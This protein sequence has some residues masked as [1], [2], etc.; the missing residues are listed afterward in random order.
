MDEETLS[1]I[2]STP[3]KTEKPGKEMEKKKSGF[4]PLSSGPFVNINELYEEVREIVYNAGQIWSLR[5]NTTTLYRMKLPGLV[6]VVITNTSGKETTFLIPRYFLDDT[7]CVVKDIEDPLSHTHLMNVNV[8]GK[9][10]LNL[11]TGNFPHIMTYQKLRFLLKIHSA[12]SEM[13]HHMLSLRNLIV[14]IHRIMIQ[15]CEDQ[16]SGDGFHSRRL[17]RTLNLDTLLDD[18]FEQLTRSFGLAFASFI[19]FVRSCDP[20]RSL[21]FSMVDLSLPKVTSN[22]N[23]SDMID[24]IFM[25]H[26]LKLTASS[27]S[28]VDL[29]VDLESLKI[30]CPD[31]F[32]LQL[33]QVKWWIDATTIASRRVREKSAQLQCVRALVSLAFEELGE[34]AD[35]NSKPE[36]KRVKRSTLDILLKIIGYQET[37]PFMFRE[38]L[39]NILRTQYNLTEDERHRLGIACTQNLSLPKLSEEKLEELRISEFERLHA[40]METYL[41]TDISL[42][43]PPTRGPPLQDKYPAVYTHDPPKVIRKVKSCSELCPKNKFRIPMITGPLVYDYSRSML[44]TTGY[45]MAMPNLA[46]NLGGTPSSKIATGTV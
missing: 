33:D 27:F 21:N 40:H 32:H 26:F 36:S 9:V 2:R 5:Y 6:E 16:P 44:R 23:L 20:K 8:A 29:Y 13:D 39:I 46:N 31:V 22:Q 37:F 25:A 18:L 19:H 3:D 7:S 42:M 10:N 43:M 34:H 35:V 38:R 41:D 4:R 28:L 17:K 11:S 15:E 24:D 30:P 1:K 12:F 14:G 45:F